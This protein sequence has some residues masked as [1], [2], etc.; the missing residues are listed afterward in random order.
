MTGKYVFKRLKIVLILL[1][2]VSICSSVCHVNAQEAKK[3]IPAGI[4]FGM[5]I[6]Y[7]GINVSGYSDMPELRGSSNPALSSGLKPG[8]MI[9]AV[10]KNAVNTVNELTQLIKEAQ[11]TPIN[12]R[13][14]RAGKEQTIT[15]SAKKCSDGI[16]R[17]GINVKDSIA[18]IGTVTYISAEDGQFGGLGHG[19][20]DSY[21]GD[22][23]PMKKGT[24]CD[25][26]INQ[27]I[28]GQKGTPGGIRGSFSIKRT[29]GLFKNTERGVFGI[30]N[31]YTNIGIEPIET[32]SRDEIFCGNAELIC[33]LDASGPK[34]YSVEIEKKD[35]NENV[36]T[37]NF[38]VKVT[39]KRLLEKTGGIIQGM[40]GSPLIQNGKLIGAVTHVLIN[41][42][43]R[44]YG[45]F[46]DN[47]I[48]ASL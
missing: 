10:N 43:T 17:L 48:D 12:L 46:I 25:V 45:I 8:D 34:R 15:V 35:V 28:K 13:I 47:M 19:I 41:D 16:Y 27:T 29:G 2:S 3:Y 23:L 18:G 22:V 39:D 4:P 20:C 14:I 9:K 24:V 40:S 26:V 11:G 42:P 21:T 31:D 44:G 6:E 36:K 38:V 33:T 1:F 7:N 5:N 30:L 37:R 32:A